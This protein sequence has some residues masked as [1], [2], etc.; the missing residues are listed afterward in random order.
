M[1]QGCGKP[2]RRSNSCA[3]QWWWS[4]C[5]I[6][7]CCHEISARFE[8]TL[9]TLASATS[10]AVRLETEPHVHP[11]IDQAEWTASSSCFVHS[12]LVVPPRPRCPTSVRLGPVRLGVVPA[13]VVGLERHDSTMYGSGRTLSSSLF[14]LLFARGPIRQIATAV[15]RM[16]RLTARIW[17]PL[18]HALST[19]SRSPLRHL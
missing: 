12:D 11:Q 6:A 7:R 10:D 9:A 14:L 2:S 17:S 8:F 13:G 19:A 4:H 18:R 5:R 15:C 16:S 1:L 3:R